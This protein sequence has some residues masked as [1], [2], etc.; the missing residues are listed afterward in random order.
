MIID[1]ANLKV[2]DGKKLMDAAIEHLENELVAVRAGK[3]SPAMLNNVFVD[4]Y[5]AHSPISQVANVTTAD[6]RTIT[7]QPWERNMIQPIEKAIM[8]A[9]LGV[10]PQNDGILIRITIPALTEERRKDLVKQC[11]GIG[12]H[13]KV[14]IRNVRR[15]I[16]QAVKNMKKDGLPEDIEKDIEHKIQEQ[17]DKHIVHIDKLIA[18]KEKEIMTV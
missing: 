5:G 13:A 14:S 17:T 11:K 2:S 16:L 15:D 10:T 7:I 12:E 8:V 3:A 1:A 4:Y 9:N 6:A 18:A